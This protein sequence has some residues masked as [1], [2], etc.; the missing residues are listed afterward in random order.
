MVIYRRRMRVP[1]STPPLGYVVLIIARDF[2]RN[3][4]HHFCQENILIA[5][6]KISCRCAALSLLVLKVEAAPGDLD[7]TF[8]GTG[9]MRVALGGRDDNGNAMARQSDGKLIVAGQSFTETN[10]G[11]ITSCFSLVRYNANG[12]VDTSFGSN[13]KVLTLAGGAHGSGAKAV[14]ILSDGTIVAAGYAGNASNSTD[15]ALAKYNSDGTLYTS[16]PFGT[17]GI[18]ITD[19]AS[20]K[21]AANAIVIQPEAGNPLGKIVLAGQ[22]GSQTALARYHA[23]GTPDLTFDGD[24]KVTTAISNVSSGNAVAVLNDKIFV[25]GDAHN[26]TTDNHFGFL[27]CYN[28]NGLLNQSFPTAGGGSVSLSRFSCNGGPLENTSARSLAILAATVGE[29]KIIVAGGYSCPASNDVAGLWSYD[30][31]DGSL[32][33]GFGP[34]GRAG[35]GQT[36][37]TFNAVKIQNSAGVPTRIVV[38]GTITTGATTSDF[39]VARYLLDGTPDTFNGNGYASADIDN[40]DSGNAVF[41]QPSDNKIVVAGSSHKVAPLATGSTSSDDDFALVRFNTNG[42]L[43]TGFSGDGKEVDEIGDAGGPAR[44]TLIQPDGKIIVAGDHVIARFNPDGSFDSGF[45]ANGKTKIPGEITGAAFHNGGVVLAANTSPEGSNYFL[46][47][48]LNEDGTFDSTFDGDGVSAATIGASGAHASAIA[49]Q[50]DA[51]IVIA[52][53]TDTG[54]A[55]DFAL[56]RFL[57]GGTLNTATFG[58]GGKV[59]TS[60]GVVSAFGQAMAIQADGKIIV[61]GK[62]DDGDGTGFDFAVVRYNTDGS[63]DNFFSGDGKQI[64]SIGSGNDSAYA[65]T[66]QGDKIVLA[67]DSFNGINSDFALVRY[68][69]NGAPDNFFD[70][71]G[72]V[73]TPGG[74]AYALAIQ[75]NKILAAGFS[76]NDFTVFRYNDNG[77]LDNSFSGDGKT[78]IDVGANSPDLAFGLAVDSLGRAVAAGGA[79]GFFGITRI[80]GDP[81]LRITGITRRSSDSHLIVDGLAV[82]G[83][84]TSLED[85]GSPSSASFNFFASLAPDADGMWEVDAG[86]PSSPHFFRAI[87]P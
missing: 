43:D 85:S 4:R 71:D 78:I 21:D 70:G 44:A 10:A 5:Y 49:V 74:T 29:E 6:L 17:G 32:D 28:S 41:V 35:F 16:T 76:N 66:M 77:S 40:S 12:T 80:V 9:K 31:N 60:V 20:A 61:A 24:G 46:V 34:G 45:G 7:S 63:P 56:V 2:P 67:G 59:T 55:I 64:T 75:G 82:P 23:D 38:G 36:G 13:G 37:A 14:A 68:S 65:V 69:S 53:W 57:P 30:A 1:D 33:N 11:G 72:K 81:F 42:T 73:T 3:F 22:S 51:R 83:I 50:A 48:R 47:C 87:A 54:S 25:A 27:A 19:F 62:A 8:G 18:V 26:S 86:M 79:G 52:G 39:L 84:T 58:V 15:F